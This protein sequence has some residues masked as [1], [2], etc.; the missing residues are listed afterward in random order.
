MQSADRVNYICE[1]NSS[2]CFLLCWVHQPLPL[3]CTFSRIQHSARAFS[4]G[5]SGSEAL[6]DPH[7]HIWGLFEGSLRSV[8][9]CVWNQFSCIITEQ[10]QLS[11]ARA[12]CKCW[13]WCGHC[14]QS[15]QRASRCWHIRY[16]APFMLL[17]LCISPPVHRLMKKLWESLVGFMGVFKDILVGFRAI[18]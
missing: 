6:H 10:N 8:C 5:Q 16:P 18:M 15:G 14:P 4:A 12:E 3:G 1:Q 17:I 7:M 9:T 13:S 2:S 11:S